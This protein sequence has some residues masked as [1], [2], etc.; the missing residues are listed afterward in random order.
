[1][2]NSE[3]KQHGD[4][5]G[6]KNYYRENFIIALILIG[7]AVFLSCGGDEEV[8][9]GPSKEDL[10]GSWEIISI[11]GENPE[12]YF[13]LGQDEDGVESRVSKNDYAFVANNSFFINFGFET[14]DDLGDGISLTS[15]MTISVKGSYIVSGSS[16]SLFLEEVNVR[17]EPNDFWQSVG[18]TEEALEKELARDRFLDVENSTW[19]LTG[20][21]LTLTSDDVKTVLRKK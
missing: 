2:S 6:R 11:D 7:L 9:S 21:T 3:S 4:N 19:I 14:V 15:E 20:N 12:T 10:V 13:D 17:L 1:M 18:V 5:M 16:L 8:P